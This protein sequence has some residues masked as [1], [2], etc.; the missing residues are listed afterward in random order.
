MQG[1]EWREC[2]LAQCMSQVI[3]CA[4]VNPPSRPP[5]IY[6]PPQGTSRWL[7]SLGRKRGQR[8]LPSDHR[9]LD[10]QRPVLRGWPRVLLESRVS[11]SDGYLRNTGRSTSLHRTH[12][13]RVP[14]TAGS[15]DAKHRYRPVLT[16]LKHREGCKTSS[17][18]TLTT[19]RS[20][21]ASGAQP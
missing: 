18:R 10:P 17:H 8:T 5:T 13:Q 14:Q 12:V 20:Q 4:R 9:T 6:K 1:D 2:S 11:V 21:S 19:G 16:G 3:K 15:P 7:P